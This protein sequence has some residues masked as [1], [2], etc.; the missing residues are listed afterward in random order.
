M[1]DVQIRMRPNPFRHT[2]LSGIDYGARLSLSWTDSGSLLVQCGDCGRF[3][4]KC[5][6][7]SLFILDKETKWHDVRIDYHN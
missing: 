1:S 7:C 5:D 6:D 3:E 4:I 2:V